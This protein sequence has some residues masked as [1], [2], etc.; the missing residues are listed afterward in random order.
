VK[1]TA[2]IDKAGR[3]V[4]PK[5]FRDALHLRPGDRL[6][7][8]TEGEALVLEPEPVYAKTRIA[9]DGWPVL[10]NGGEPLPLSVFN[11]VLDQIR[12][13]RD[14]HNLGLDE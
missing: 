9:E 3:L 4:V 14:R 2:Q 10:E 1:S 11:D 8:R 6:R 5:A 7:V 13:E 12:E